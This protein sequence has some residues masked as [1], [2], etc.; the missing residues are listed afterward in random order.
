MLTHLHTN[1][2]CFPITVA[3][4]SSCNGGEKA[5]K[6]HAEVTTCVSDWTQTFQTPAGFPLNWISPKWQQGQQIPQPRISPAPLSWFSTY[7][8]QVNIPRTRDKRCSV[9]RHF[10]YLTKKRHLK[11]WK[12][13]GWKEAWWVVF[14]CSW[15]RLVS[16]LSQN[17]TTLGV[18][19]S[20][21][22][23]L[24]FQILLLFQ[25]TSLT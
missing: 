3:E 10:E 19:C 12:H 22:T 1:S 14:C 20:D 23:L 24:C 6:G 16:I 7:P 18:S 17:A 25:L 8:W 5:E 15:M 4:M 21:T 13:F 2:G 9:K 11:G